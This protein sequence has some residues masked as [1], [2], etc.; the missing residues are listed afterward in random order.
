MKAAVRYYSRTG[1]TK[2]LAEAAADA[3]G[4]PLEEDVDILF[5]CNSVYWNCID[6]KVKAFLKSPGHKIGMLVNVSSAALKESTY[7]QVKAYAAEV[8]VPVD[9]REFHCKGSFMALHKGKPDQSDIEN[10]KRFAKE[11]VK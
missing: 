5:L 7:K 11:I 2:K 10:V 3:I 6:G 8:G 9:E 1:N 4:Q